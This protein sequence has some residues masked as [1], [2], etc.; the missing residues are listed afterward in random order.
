MTR[1]T[2]AKPSAFA[3][4]LTVCAL[5]VQALSLGGCSTVS[6][7]DKEAREA[8]AAATKSAKEGLVSKQTAAGAARQAGVL[9]APVAEAEMPKPAGRK[10][11]SRVNLQAKDTPAGQ[12][13]AGILAGTGY[14]PV[15]TE[16]A[17]KSTITMTL[18]DV[19]FKEALAALRESRGYD[20]RV[21]GKLVHIDKSAKTSRTFTLNYLSMTRN[22]SSAMGGNT[23]ATNT[24]GS[25]GTSGAYGTTP[26]TTPAYGTTGVPGATGTMTGTAAQNAATSSGSNIVSRTLE[27]TWASLKLV[28]EGIVGNGDGDKVAVDPMSGTVFVRAS[29][30]KVREVEGHL[31]TIDANLNRQVMIELQVVRVDLNDGHQTGVNW[32]LASSSGRSG[33]GSLP[34]GGTLSPLSSDMSAGPLSVANG[35]MTSASGSPLGMF[36]KAANF[37]AML[38]FLDTQGTTHVLSNPRVASM[39]NRMAVLKVGTEALYATNAS[40]TT[41]TTTTGTSSAPSISTESKFS[42]L[43]VEVTPQISSTGKITLHTRIPVTSVQQKVMSI[44]LGTSGTVAFPT[45]E[46]AV[47]DTDTVIQVQD[48]EVA[49]VGGLMTVSGAST[50][51]TMP[52]VGCFSGEC[53]SGGKKSELFI[54]L[55]ATV[56]KSES[57]WGAGAYGFGK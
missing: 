24:Y 29:H 7:M 19:T 23:A 26:S 21:E 32:S 35:V 57:D 17:E 14:T 47:Q 50:K 39:N 1:I 27:D 15:L 28:L 56:I 6:P 49:V 12:V 25:T 33:I 9:T 54:L 22:G 2:T 36:F 53:S 3:T 8:V 51:S 31:R 18:G 44:S 42:G 37:A 10:G 52:V 43:L 40:S 48:G 55:K 5:V 45:A 20:F 4:R 13:F 38:S 11:D 41:T 30:A 46:S 16:A 34:S